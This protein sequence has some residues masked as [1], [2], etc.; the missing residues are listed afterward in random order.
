MPKLRVATGLALA[1]VMIA[2]IVYLPTPWLAAFLL[3][4]C[5][6]AAREWAKLAGVV[7]RAGW[8]VYAITRSGALAIRWVA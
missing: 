3:L 7:T 5:L 2:A 1:I 8:L 6:L 4:I